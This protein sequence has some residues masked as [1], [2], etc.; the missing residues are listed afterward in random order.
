M[1]DKLPDCQTD[2]IGRPVWELVNLFAA[3]PAQQKSTRQSCL[4]I[5][6]PPGITK[7][8]EGEWVQAP[9]EVVAII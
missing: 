5:N 8:R 7:H 4:N 9:Q 3:R 2:R 6:K 1:T